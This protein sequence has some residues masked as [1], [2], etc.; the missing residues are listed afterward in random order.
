[1]VKPVGPRLAVFETHELGDGML[2]FALLPADQR[3]TFD[4]S[5]ADR[6]EGRAPERTGLITGRAP[7]LRLSWVKGAAHLDGKLL[8]EPPGEPRPRRAE[9]DVLPRSVRLLQLKPSHSATK[10]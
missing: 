6:L 4:Q 10:A 2:A 7:R 5:L 3:E 1:M 9:L 8:P